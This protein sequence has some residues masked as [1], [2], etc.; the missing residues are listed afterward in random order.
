MCAELCG[1][2]HSTM[3]QNVRVVPE[4]EFDGWL[5]EQREAGEAGGALS[6]RPARNQRG[7]GGVSPRLNRYLLE[8][9]R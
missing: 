4:G 7:S 3:R 1:I 8:A 6:L 9:Q 5:D 2:G